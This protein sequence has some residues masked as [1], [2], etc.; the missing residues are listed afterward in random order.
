MKAL[1]ILLL[2][3]SAALA[4]YYY[5]ARR[6]AQRTPREIAHVLPESVELVDTPAEIHL[7]VGKAA[8][9]ERVEVLERT[10]NW[11]RVLRS[12][13]QIGWLEAKD[14]I[15]ARTYEGGQKILRDLLKETR[16]AEGHTGAEAN[17]RLEPSRGAPQL[18][19][20]RAN[21]KVEV[22]GRQ[23]VARPPKANEAGGGPEPATGANKESGAELRDA[24]YLVRSEA[25]AGWVLGRFVDLDVPPEIS[26]YAQGVNLVA[27]L[28]LR[29][30]DDNGSKVPEYLVAER[31]GTQDFDFNHLRVFT[32]WVK[33]H[34]YVTAYVESNLAGGFPIRVEHVNDTPYFW[35][36]LFDKKGGKYQRVY[37]LFDTIVRPIGSVEGW[38]SDVMPSRAV[39]KRTRARSRRLR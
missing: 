20:F 32:W 3:A 26:V 8:S 10:R 23:L 16:Q 27:W 11:A 34:R 22:F 17:L 5:A 14:L 30:V 21:Q 4:Y 6:A 29:N 25:R 36:R 28:V 39:T 33:N 31:I 15:D 24:W 9:G 37:G 18:A 7:E 12:S 13:R 2:I 19:V 38:E 1:L 35:L